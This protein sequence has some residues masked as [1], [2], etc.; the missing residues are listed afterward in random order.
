MQ[1]NEF[2]DEAEADIEDLFAP[3]FYIKL[4]A[5]AYKEKLGGKTLT[6]K[7]LAPGSPRISKRID[8]YF[9]AEGINN[10]VFRHQPPAAFLLCEQAKLMPSV[11]DATLTRASALF[12]RVNSLLK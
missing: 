12:Q 6:L 7:A 8:A 3:A 10:G 4:A 1:I 9:K 5:G 11:D 2:T